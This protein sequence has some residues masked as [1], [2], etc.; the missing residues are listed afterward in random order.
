LSQRRPAAAQSNSQQRPF[1]QLLPLPAHWAAC[2]QPVPPCAIR[3][4]QAPVLGLQ[5]LPQL[6]LTKALFTQD[7]E[8]L[9]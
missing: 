3:P 1:W 8:V 7:L 5:P 9:P 2:P 4:L 6:T